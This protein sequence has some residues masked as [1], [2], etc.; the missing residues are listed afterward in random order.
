MNSEQLSKEILRL[1]GIYN[2]YL[3]I[4]QN[5]QKNY[6]KIVNEYEQMK[7]D[8]QY[9]E[10]IKDWNKVT[11]LKLKIPYKNQ[12]RSECFGTL[13]LKKADT[14]NALNNLNQ[15]KQNLVGYTS[16][17]EALSTS[18]ILETTKEKQKLTDTE[19]KILQKKIITYALAGLAL[20][21]LI[22]ISFWAYDKFSK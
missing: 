2:G 20:I 22:A 13:Q 3:A 7:K 21:T 16:E 8:L 6:D 12:E 14:V 5:W 15:A 4:E 17:N 19:Q 9:A 18:N 11:E 1:Q 10:F